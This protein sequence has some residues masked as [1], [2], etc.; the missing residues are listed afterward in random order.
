MCPVWSIILPLYLP[1]GQ[2]ED[3]VPVI[4]IHLDP[5]H[6]PLSLVTKHKTSYRALYDA[7]RARVGFD[8][9]V[10]FALGEVL[11][12]NERGEIMGRRGDECLFLARGS[13]GDACRR[14]GV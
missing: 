5:G 11:L 9:S 8:D 6:V 3:D 13:L 14:D 1:L 4:P 10:T 2:S 7:A 12:Q